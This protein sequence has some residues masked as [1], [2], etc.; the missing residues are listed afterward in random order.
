ML[1]G[2]PGSGKSTW[3]KSKD[4]DWGKTVVVSTDQ[5]IELRALSQGLTYNDMFESTI[6]DATADMLRTVHQAVR[7]GTDIVWD[8]TNTTVASRAKKL[9]NIPSSYKKI[10]V[11]FKTPESEEHARRLDRP[12]KSIPA[13]V[14]KSMITSLEIPTLDEG[15]DEVIIV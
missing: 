5:Y 12:G 8:Q 1:V 4:F 7:A 11:Y 6:K 13:H 3:V 14:M 9:R 10:A 15:F 2:V